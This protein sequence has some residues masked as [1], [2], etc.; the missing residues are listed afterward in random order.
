MDWIGLEKKWYPYTENSSRIVLLSV[1]QTIWYPPSSERNPPVAGPGRVRSSGRCGDGPNGRDTYIYP[2]GFLSYV[3]VGTRAS[4][5]GGVTA[6]RGRPRTTKY[7]HAS[8]APASYRTTLE[9]T[10]FMSVVGSVGCS[11]VPSN[12]SQNRSSAFIILISGSALS[13]ETRFFFSRHGR[14]V[15][16]WPTRPVYSWK[17]AKP[18]DTCHRYSRILM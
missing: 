1:Y 2:L 3:L 14:A 12:N 9:R 18:V 15:T 4:L 7:K 8:A 17:P 5:R 6:Y 11:T 10:Y 16:L 13:A